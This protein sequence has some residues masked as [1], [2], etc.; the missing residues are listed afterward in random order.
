MPIEYCHK[1]FETILLLFRDEADK[2]NKL[3]TTFVQ[4][5]SHEI[6]TPLN[7]LVGFAQLLSLPDG[8][9]TPEEKEEFSEVVSNSSTVL[10]GLI[11]D[12]LNMSDIETGNYKISISPFNPV[13]ACEFAL[14]I[15]EG[16][17]RPSTKLV[18][19]NKLGGELEINSD[20]MRVQ[21]ILT[22]FLTNAINLSFSNSYTQKS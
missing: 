15:V 5:M 2:A 10:I 19:E 3:K 6:R 20:I 1:Q 16:R 18:F 14:K 11:D 21:Q 22:N 12:I 4:N 13:S 9:L 7:A 17:V 8:T